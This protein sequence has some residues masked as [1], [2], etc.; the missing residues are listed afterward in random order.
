MWRSIALVSVFVL[1]GVSVSA[2]AGTPLNLAKKAEVFNVDLQRYY[3]LDGQVAPKLKLPTPQRSFI[4]YNMPDNAYM[5]GIYA[6]MLAMR[7]AASKDPA[8]RAQASQALKGLD[9]LTT[10]SGKKG[11]LARAAVPLDMPFEDGG[12]WQPSPNG[13][14]KWWADVSSDQMDG[15]LY[16]YVMLYDLTADDAEKKLI[17]KNVSDLVSYVLD[18]G[19]RIIDYHG[20]PTQ[21]GNYTKEH[22]T[23][24]EPMN[25]LL[26]LQHL[27]I[28][29]HVTGNERFA[30]EYE[31]LARGEGYA[32]L[33]VK[34]RRGGFGRVNY[35]DDV[36]LWLA[37]YPLL[38]IEK[39]PELK[40]FY[41]ASLRRTW[42]GEGNLR[43]IKHEQNPIYA[44]AVNRFL[45]DTSG[46]PAGIQTLQ[47]FPLD[48]K[49][50]RL[51]IARYERELG[52][53][54][55]PTPQSPAPAKGEV[56]PV[57]RR[58]KY[59]STWVHDPYVAGTREDFALEYSGLDYLMAY[60][61]GRYHGY[62]TAAM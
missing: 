54:F 53:R 9:L 31:R 34:A 42:E 6:G 58:P 50:N 40:G 26:L 17:A 14:H 21:Y 43:G 32:K 59:W 2:V 18:N 51:S 13:R 4:A 30:Q 45:G 28:A 19:Y 12:D 60:W 3:A 16:G 29:H 38:L 44:F 7:Y 22:I 39:D 52:F 55:D 35:S 27:K 20:R 57:D 23:Q 47:W 41:E 36:L 15:A 33:A 8:A 24:R 48:M 61:Q 10:V 46:T 62:I 11:L 37:Y 49:L 5:T 1:M 56:V 25:G